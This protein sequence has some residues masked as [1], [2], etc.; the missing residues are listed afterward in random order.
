MIVLLFISLSEK[1]INLLKFSNLKIKNFD[2][3]PCLTQLKLILD[4]NPISGISQEYNILIIS[5]KFILFTSLFDFVFNLSLIY[6]IGVLKLFAEPLLYRIRHSSPQYEEAVRLLNFLDLFVGVS[7][8][9]I[10]SDS[11]LREFIGKSYF[12]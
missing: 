2:L 9:E 6:E 11:L 7:T 1:Q 5:I 4:L 3:H 12:E 8:D 10:P